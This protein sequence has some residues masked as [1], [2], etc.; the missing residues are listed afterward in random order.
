[1]ESPRPV[2]IELFH[3]AYFVM[4]VSKNKRQRYSAAQFDA[5]DNTEETV[6]D[7]IKKNPKLKLEDK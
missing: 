3:G 4:Y 2:T 7:W 6:K 5:R 1:M